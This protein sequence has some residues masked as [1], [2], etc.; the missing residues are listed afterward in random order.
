MPFQF[1]WHRSWEQQRR[2]LYRDGDERIGRLG[3]NQLFS[4]ST[5]RWCDQASG[6]TRVRVNISETP[7]GPTTIFYVWASAGSEHWHIAVMG[8]ISTTNR[9]Q[10]DL[11]VVLGRVPDYS[12]LAISSVLPD[13]N[14]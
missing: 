8:A 6:T 10:G 12:S 13:A 7:A 14:L 9:A 5:S 11:T 4:A 1:S 2:N 3:L